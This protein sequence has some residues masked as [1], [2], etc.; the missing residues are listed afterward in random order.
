VGAARRGLNSIFI[1]GAWVLWKHR[2]RCV[3]DAAAPSL[4]VALTQASEERLMWEVVGARGISSLTA[5][6][7][8]G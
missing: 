3:F 7:Y 5:P 2:N 4:V 6:L 1:L 8:V